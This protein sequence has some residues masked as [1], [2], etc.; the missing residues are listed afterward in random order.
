[1]YRLR[2]ELREYVQDKDPETYEEVLRYARRGEANLQ[3]RQQENHERLSRGH[4]VYVVEYGRSS[5]NGPESNPR[6][7]ECPSEKGFR[8]SCGKS[9]GPRLCY[10]CDAPDHLAQN[11]PWSYERGNEF[12]GSFG[13]QNWNHGVDQQDV[14][15]G[16]LWNHGRRIF[17]RSANDPR[18]CFVCGDQ[19][20]LA[21]ECPYQEQVGN[22]D[23]LDEYLQLAGNADYSIPDNLQP[24][25]VDANVVESLGEG[26]AANVEEF[27]RL[28]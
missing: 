2:E 4:G 16:S 6:A 1:M 19:G 12:D 3:R 18:R 7:W 13:G 27:I 15:G 21:R 26:E 20:H 5:N 22:G 17:G 25:R 10:V 9:F 28:F 11:C 23:V 14:N 8:R 24:R